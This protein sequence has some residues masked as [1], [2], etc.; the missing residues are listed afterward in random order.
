MLLQLHMDEILLARQLAEQ[1]VLGPLLAS[2]P[3]L[4]L[5]LLWKLPRWRCVYVSNHC[6]VRQRLRPCR[7]MG[8]SN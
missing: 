8:K 4:A 2:R 5:L 3:Q 6:L 1:T 7:V